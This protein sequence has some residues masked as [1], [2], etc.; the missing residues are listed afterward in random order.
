MEWVPG[1]PLSYS[2]LWVPG[3]CDNWLRRL[4]EAFGPWRLMTEAKGVTADTDQNKQHMLLLGLLNV[5]HS[6]GSTFLPFVDQ[7]LAELKVKFTFQVP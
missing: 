5:N 7:T 3:S 1:A 4:V 6:Q 2:S